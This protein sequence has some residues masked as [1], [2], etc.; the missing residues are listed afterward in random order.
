MKPTKPTILQLKV[1]ILG[2]LCLTFLT[3]CISASYSPSTKIP[4]YDEKIKSVIIWNTGGLSEKYSTLV[5]RMDNT[6]MQLKKGFDG[7]GIAAQILSTT[8]LELNKSSK[9][10]ELAN[11]TAATHY[12]TLRVLTASKRDASLVVEFYTYEVTLIDVKTKKEVWRTVVNANFY[13]SADA[14]A[15]Q[16]FENMAKDKLF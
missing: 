9:L 4:N 3:G 7:R 13:S 11:K 1:F 6:S 5:D 8:A 2:M 12:I 15:S 14:M 16:I 10:Q